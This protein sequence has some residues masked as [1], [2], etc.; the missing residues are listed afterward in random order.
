MPFHTQ[1]LRWQAPRQGNAHGALPRAALFRLPS[2]FCNDGLT[3]VF[4]FFSYIE[5]RL[6]SHR[7]SCEN[8]SAKIV[9][10]GKSQTKMHTILSF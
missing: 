2:G 6:I 1:P 7:R 8:V 9:H 3:G 10:L 5:L 4:V